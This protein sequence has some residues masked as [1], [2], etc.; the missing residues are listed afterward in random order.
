MGML[1]FSIL[2]QWSVVGLYSRGP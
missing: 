2:P 1:K